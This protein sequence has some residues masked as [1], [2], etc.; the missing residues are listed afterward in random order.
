MVLL[1]FLYIKERYDDKDIVFVFYFF[2]LSFSVNAI[3]ID[4]Y[5]SQYS[6][7]SENP[8]LREYVRKWAWFMA[9]MDAQQKYN[10]SSS[11][12]INELLNDYGEKYG[13]LGFQKIASDCKNNSTLESGMELNKRECEIII[14]IAKK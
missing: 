14:D 10:T 2:S 6:K 12:K 9:M 11:Y 5:L 13:S 4:D 8:I 1:S 7:L 3:T